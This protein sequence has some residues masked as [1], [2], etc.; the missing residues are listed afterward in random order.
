MQPTAAN[1][2]GAPST[3]N[4]TEAIQGQPQEEIMLTPGTT[5]NDWRI[6]SKLG[7]GVFGAV[8]KCSKTRA[9]DNNRTANE[10]Y[11]IKVGS[12]RLVWDN[13]NSFSLQLE[14]ASHAVN[15]LAIEVAVYDAL[16]Q[17]PNETRRHYPIMLERGQ[18]QNYN[19]IVMSLVGKSLQVRMGRDKKWFIR[20]S[21][22]SGPEEKTARQQIHTRHGTDHRTS[23]TGSAVTTSP[24]KIPSPRCEFPFSVNL[25]A[26]NA[27]VFQIKPA[28]FAI[29]NGTDDGNI[30]ILDL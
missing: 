12:S 4:R 20:F 19:F 21:H 7:A 28:N 26:P 15:L 2:A 1:D 30:Y 5:I 3:M 10:E 6:I 29:G 22:F 24:G 8:Y 16:Q 23:N 11:A 27:F 13:K 17:N 14:K 18:W 25:A 9:T